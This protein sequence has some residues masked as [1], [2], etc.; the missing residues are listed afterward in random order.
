MAVAFAMLAA[1]SFGVLPHLL[2]RG[3]RRAPEASLAAFTQNAIAF[4][5]SAIVATALSQ[6]DRDLVPFLLIGL[7]VPGIAQLLLVR[8][9]P[10]SGPSRVSVV[11][12][13]S[14]LPSFV[15]AV[16][17]LGEPFSAVL[18]AGAVLIVAGS[19]VLALERH[20]P[21]HVRSLGLVLAGVIAMCFAVR[22]NLVRHFALS[23]D[24]GPELAATL[25]LASAAALS[26]V[27]AA[28]ERPGDMTRRLR[29]ASL[30]YA[31]AGFCLAV[32]YVGTFEAFDRG[33]VTIV[34]PLLGTASLWA[35][36]VSA[37]F[38][39]RTEGVGRHLIGGA[40]LLVAGSA[41]IAASR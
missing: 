16:V 39:R 17:L 23:T 11:I 6:W 24:V 12:N 10:L 32:A 9:V 40:V 28:V 13:T 26:L 8:A 27:V 21:A 1:V 29:A 38:L 4:L 37:I 25:V 3:L 35:V 2:R 14:P 18:L 20:R 30:A 22:D 15:I 33:R 5:L 7:L 19:V 31:P 34:A 41:A 36:L